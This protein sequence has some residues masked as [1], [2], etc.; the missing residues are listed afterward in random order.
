MT[1]RRVTVA[2]SFAGACLSAAVTWSLPWW[3]VTGWI[4]VGAAAG[5]GAAI[6]T[7]TGHIPNRCSFAGF[8]A[9][10]A[11]GVCGAIDD[12][13][14]VVWHVLIGMA[15]A[16][17][18]FL[19]LFLLEQMGGGDVKL[20]AVLGGA[21]GLM[22]TSASLVVTLAICIAVS[23]AGMVVVVRHGRKASIRLGPSLVV[24]ALAG[25]VAYRHGLFA[26]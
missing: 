15:I 21:A 23:F 26:I 9:V 17:A 4:G 22:S 25:V 11:A 6:D 7:M 12:R 2:A 8:V 19:V 18:L 13:F 20:A 14:A 1:G 5:A 10:V 24:G 3:I 16:S